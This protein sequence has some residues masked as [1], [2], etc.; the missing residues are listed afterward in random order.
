MEFA[1]AQSR[2]DRVAAL[3]ASTYRDMVFD[4]PQ[5]DYHTIDYD[6]DVKAADAKSAP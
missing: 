6:R 2:S 1:L 5:W 4:D 3:A